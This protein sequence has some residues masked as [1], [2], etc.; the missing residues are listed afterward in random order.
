MSGEKAGNVTLIMLAGRRAAM[1]PAAGLER[2]EVT[3]KATAAVSQPA[4]SRPAASHPPTAPR[5]PQGALPK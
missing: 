2:S 4:R 3:L 5:R 1:T